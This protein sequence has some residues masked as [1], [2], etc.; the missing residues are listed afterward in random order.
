MVRCMIRSHNQQ[1][2]IA[3]GDDAENM[4]GSTLEP[5][6]RYQ[7]CCSN[8]FRPGKVLRDI[9]IG[10]L[11]VLAIAVV[12]AV[13]FVVC[14]YVLPETESADKLKESAFVGNPTEDELNINDINEVE[15]TDET[16]YDVRPEVVL[17]NIRK[18]K[19]LDNHTHESDHQ[20]EHHHMGSTHGPE[21]EPEPEPEPKSVDH[22]HMHK[23]E[24]RSQEHM[25]GEGEGKMSQ[26]DMMGHSEMPESEM[27]SEQT[28]DEMGMPHEHMHEHI[29]AEG[30]MEDEHLFD[31]SEMSHGP[32]MPH[33]H[34]V[35][36]S[37]MSHETMHKVDAQPHDHAHPD[38]QEHEHSDHQDHEHSDH[39]D[40]VHSDHQ[41]HEHSDHQGHGH[42]N[43]PDHVHTDMETTTKMVSEHT[44][45]EQPH[46]HTMGHEHEETAFVPSAPVNEEALEVVG[47][48]AL[49]TT[50]EMPTERTVIS[51]AS[52]SGPDAKVQIQSSESEFTGSSHS[53]VSFEGRM[54]DGVLPPLFETLGPR[55]NGSGHFASV[56]VFHN[57]N[58]EIAAETQPEK[59]PI[60]FVVPEFNIDE[61]TAP[62][63]PHDEVLSMEPATAGSCRKRHLEMC[64]DLPYGLTALPNWANDQTEKDLNESSLPF[65]RD[66]IV[67]SGCSPRARQYACGILEPPC[68]SDGSI[69]PPCRTFCRSVAAT[70]Q[71]FVLSAVSLRNVFDCEKF[72]DSTDPSVC[73]HMT[74]EP[75]IGMEHRCGDGRCVARRLV[76]DGLPD[77]VDQS[78][79]ATCPNHVQAPGDEVL[80]EG[81]RPVPGIP[82]EQDRSSSPV[83]ELS[84]KESPISALPALLVEE[85][86]TEP[87]L[88]DEILPI[89]TEEIIATTEEY[90]A[91]NVEV[92]EEDSLLHFPLTTEAV[93]VH[94]EPSFSEALF[95]SETEVVP[96]EE[97]VTTETPLSAADVAESKS[98]DGDLVSSSAPA[99]LCDHENFLCYDGEKCVAR[100]AVCDGLQHCTDGSDESNCTDT[101][102][103]SCATTTLCIP[104]SWL[105][106]GTDDCLDNSDEVNCDVD[107]PSD[108]ELSSLNIH[109]TGEQL[110]GLA[111]I[112]HF[113]FPGGYQSNSFQNTFDISSE[114]ISSDNEANAY[115]KN[116]PE[117]GSNE[118]YEED[119]GYQ[120]EDSEGVYSSSESINNF[121]YA[122]PNE[123]LFAMNDA[124][125]ILPPNHKQAEQYEQFSEESYIHHHP[126]DA[127]SPKEFPVEDSVVSLSNNA[128]DD[129]KENHESSSETLVEDENYALPSDHQ[130]EHGQ[131]TFAESFSQESLLP[132]SVET[133][134]DDASQ[135]QQ[136]EELQYISS[137]E[138][139]NTDD[140]TAIDYYEDDSQPLSEE[141]PSD[142]SSYYYDEIS[143]AN[144]EDSYPES[145]EEI[146]QVPF[147]KDSGFVAEYLGVDDPWVDQDDAEADIMYP[148]SEYQQTSSVSDSHTFTDDLHQ[149]SYQINSMENEQTENI[150]SLEN[151]EAF[152]DQSLPSQNHDQAASPINPTEQETQGLL[153]TEEQQPPEVN[154]STEE[155]N[156]QESPS[157]YQ[158]EPS[159]IKNVPELLQTYEQHSLE[160]YS[161]DEMGASR[162]N[163]SD[164]Q[165]D[166]SLEEI[167]NSNVHG[168]L[169]EIQELPQE[170][171]TEEVMIDSVISHN[172]SDIQE[173]EIS[174][175][176][177]DTLGKD[178]T[179]STT[180]AP[181]ETTTS[182]TPYRQRGY[183][184]FYSNRRPTRPTFNRYTTEKTTYVT[185]PSDSSISSTS[186]VPVTNFRSRFQQWRTSRIPGQSSYESMRTKALRERFRGNSRTNINQDPADSTAESSNQQASY[187]RPVTRRTSGIQT[188]RISVPQNHFYQEEFLKESAVVPETEIE[189]ALDQ[190]PPLIEPV[191][192]PE[193]PD[194]QNFQNVDPNETIEYSISDPSETYGVPADINDSRLHLDQSS[195]TYNFEYQTDPRLLEYRRDTSE[196]DLAHNHS[197]IYLPYSP[198]QYA[199]GNLQN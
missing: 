71:E 182:E 72:P 169:Q 131:Q 104:N 122:D 105:C 133:I 89:N 44:E 168:Q 124:Q 17:E 43:H 160:S 103:F 191:V 56:D 37:E 165:G 177:N 190:T 10:F 127:R 24:G 25:P 147:I 53:P 3:R 32:K 142:S 113:P 114:N 80:V 22:E 109:T 134:I 185:E 129:L 117:E 118:P 158:N 94:E 61:V 170:V 49:E 84:P 181:A 16:R 62:I 7:G 141:Q 77:C 28:K 145:D 189:E 31:G 154:S 151:H 136:E 137:S 14:F 54:E 108:G 197:P 74:Q 15:L 19:D 88:V 66:V 143:A 173:K 183:N 78:D 125:E 59:E 175:S 95:S 119:R 68:K 34:E 135:N 166:S 176:S 130:S 152:N 38:H 148:S 55:F 186:A 58:T 52:P 110:E 106:D 115:G 85:N 87:A 155:Q 8:I 60:E 107:L 146:T 83:L 172:E 46:E 13:L 42:I 92:A 126:G 121:A 157:F 21:P 187:Q 63:L 123:Q 144:P 67:R 96:T 198:V 171:K 1:Y 26:E 69:V 184:R 57:E 162:E 45:K 188:S 39:Q 194:P 139:Y 73:F 150:Y 70:C 75:C 196:Y 33:G 11:V 140:A 180:D 9:I 51:V 199:K 12:I 36:V 161:S 76:C 40:H 79:E 2:K 65:F 93:D 27:T 20:E 167:K 30:K 99:V 82:I 132:H 91:E 81:S 149:N 90:P 18:D 64:S 86:Q 41:D 195:Q 112:G 138:D 29:T 179:T 6:P 164:R 35:N 120:I 153:P 102:C 50:P 111:P 156:V 100:S 174:L 128:D 5:D 23:D 98:M 4:C 101:G 178:I 47:A 159:S 97:F 48:P 192:F 193:N 116:W 163:N